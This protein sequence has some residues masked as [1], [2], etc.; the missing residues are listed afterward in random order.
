MTTKDSKLH[1]DME[2]HPGSYMRVLATETAKITQRS[3]NTLVWLYGI[4]E[5]TLDQETTAG[6]LQVLTVK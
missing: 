2:L 1:A 6:G 5:K 3:T 4:W